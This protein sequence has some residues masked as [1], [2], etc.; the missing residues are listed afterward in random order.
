MI[1]N[2][3]MKDSSYDVIIERNSLSKASTYFNF[4]RKTLIVTDSGIPQQYIETLKSQIE[5]VYVYTIE[6]GEQSKNFENLGLILDFLEEN[7]YD[8][9]NLDQECEE[10]I[11][12]ICDKNMLSSVSGGVNNKLNLAKKAGALGLSAL[13]AVSPAFGIGNQSDLKDQS[14]LVQK[15]ENIAKTK[16]QTKK[17]TWLNKVDKSALLNIFGWGGF[18][19]TGIG[20]V[21][22]R[23][24]LDKVNKLLENT[25]KNLKYRINKLEIENGQ[26]KTNLKT[27]EETY[28][29]KDVIYSF[30]EDLKEL[31]KI[32]TS[33]VPEMDK[34]YCFVRC[35]LFLLGIS[36][37]KHTCNKSTILEVLDSFSKDFTQNYDAAFASGKLLLGKE[38]YEKY[39]E[40][41]AYTHTSQILYLVFGSTFAGKQEALTAISESVARGKVGLRMLKVNNDASDLTEASGSYYDPKRTDIYLEY[42]SVAKTEKTGFTGTDL[43]FIDTTTFHSI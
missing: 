33:H 12:K 43:K 35:Y 6:Q 21:Y 10:L 41:A 14:E 28:I 9:N 4:N 42:C 36:I 38:N 37:M 7:N 17:Q 2:V 1:L 34:R 24:K 22:N 20:L 39:I 27:F 25:D 32:V 26:L 40:H 29:K 8:L 3:A 16:N 5:E 18:A 11:C 31:T 15:K 19:L 13:C 30:E 23:I